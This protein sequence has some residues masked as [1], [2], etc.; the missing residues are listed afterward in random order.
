MASK[1]RPCKRPRERTSDTLDTVDLW[2]LSATALSSAL[3][4][5]EASAREV[6][7]AHLARIGA[8]D[9]CVR[10]FTEVFREQAAADAAASDERR[11][12]GEARGPLDGMPVTI[13]ECYDFAGRPTTLGIPAWRGRVAAR[14]AAMVVALRDAG[15]VVLGRTN[16]S[17]TMLYVE[18]KNPI[19][20]QTANPWSL[21]H[22]PGGSSGGEAAAIAAGMSPL[23]LGTDIGGSIR[24]PAS[25]CGI[26][27]FKPSLDRLPMQGYCSVNPGQETVRAMGGPL[28][29]TVDDLSLFFRALDPRRL[30]LLDPR[31]PPV[32]WEEPESIPI[33]GLR[34][35]TYAD[36][37][38]L[39]ASAALARAVA[40]AGAALE[41]RGCEVRAFR[42]PDMRD[43]LA[44]YIGAL[45]A[46]G[47]VRIRALLAGGDVDPSI[48]ALRR[49]VAVPSPVRK[50]ASRLARA[51]GQG[52]LALLLDATG[53]KT[54]DGLWQ[55]TL[56]LREHRAKV[57]DAMA[58]QGVDALVGPAY[59]TPA[60]PHGG[61]RGFTLASSYAMLFNAHQF[62]AGVV[63]VT[64]VRPKETKRPRA[65]ESLARR[66]AAVDAES[67]GLPAG[68]QVAAP[69]WRD[70]LVLALMKA[71]ESEVARDE[72]FPAT[73]V[74]PKL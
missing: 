48:D 68:V 33:R 37:G 62:P 34:V 7:Q 46:D 23:G 1:A 45:S 39:P 55:I 38:I 57:L 40:R 36:D 65:R 19:F 16:L 52:G 53:A 63:P 59:A 29:R 50:V 2:R 3:A 54:V 35:G 72:G 41:A 58:E 24:T 17:Q 28:A 61:S 73:P 4:R 56:A 14:D 42:P 25:F 21:A 13:K 20:G 32:P 69:P 43:L 11:S 15:A 49:V 18:S 70:G 9:P 51:L 5:R 26:V 6:L 31:V 60:L 30:S 8:V 71:V 67:E 12:R 10:A 74:E 22:S 47:A 44:A 64:R 66:A 27:G